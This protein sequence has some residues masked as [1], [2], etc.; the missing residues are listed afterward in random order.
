MRAARRKYRDC[1][2]VRADHRDAE[3][4]RRRLLRERMGDHTSE[5]LTDAAHLGGESEVCDERRTNRDTASTGKRRSLYGAMAI[6]VLTYVAAT[7]GGAQ[8]NQVACA[9]QRLAGRVCIVCG[10][11][12]GQVVGLVVRSFIRSIRAP[13]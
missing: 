5:K 8:G 10:Q 9:C 12:I 2:E 6:G 11:H 13:P 3:R 1:P 4:E 7:A